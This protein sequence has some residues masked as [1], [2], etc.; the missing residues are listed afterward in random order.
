MKER[1]VIFTMM[2]AFL[3]VGCGRG[4]QPEELPP[5]TTDQ[6]IEMVAY[7]NYFGPESVAATA[8]PVA[9]LLRNQGFVAHNLIIKD[10]AGKV[11]GETPRVSRNRTTHVQLDLAPGTYQLIC[12]VP[13]HMTMTAELVVKQ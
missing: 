3:F 13:G 8:G 2:A 5:I 10:Q 1:L 4:A 7:D 9:L 6:I 11:L 12:T